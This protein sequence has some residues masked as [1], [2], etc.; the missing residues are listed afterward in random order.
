ML[1]LK[2]EEL[3]IIRIITESNFVNF[4]IQKSN[5][6]NHFIINKTKMMVNNLR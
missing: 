2:T 1:I 5:Q 6:F 4:K 3:Y